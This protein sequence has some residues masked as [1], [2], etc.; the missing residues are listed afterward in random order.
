MIFFL[1]SLRRILIFFLFNFFFLNWN[2]FLDL[3]SIITLP[4]YEDIVLSIMKY[5]ALF[6]NFINFMTNITSYMGNIFLK[7]YL[8]KL[9]NTKSRSE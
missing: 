8:I 5:L 2:I 1:F 9:K 3:K 4:T 7:I 6:I